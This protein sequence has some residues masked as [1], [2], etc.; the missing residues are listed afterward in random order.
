MNRAIALEMS[1]PPVKAIRLA[2]VLG[3]T[4]RVQ[5]NGQNNAGNGRLQ[6]ADVA[7]YSAADAPPANNLALMNPIEQSLRERWACRCGR[8]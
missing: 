3:R 8:Q 5:I 1:L 7:L 4:V 2:S 6:L